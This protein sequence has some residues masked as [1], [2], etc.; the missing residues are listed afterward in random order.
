MNNIPSTGFVYELGSLEMAADDKSILESGLAEDAV[1]EG[2]GELSD[3]IRRM[4][5]ESDITSQSGDPY[6]LMLEGKG[7]QESEYSGLP[8]LLRYGVQEFYGLRHPSESP[9]LAQDQ[10]QSAVDSKQAADQK[11]IYNQRAIGNESEFKSLAK[12]LAEGAAIARAPNENEGQIAAAEL[13]HQDALSQIQQFENTPYSAFG[14]L[15]KT[16]QDQKNAIDQLTLNANIIRDRAVDRFHDPEVEQQR[17]D[18]DQLAALKMHASGNTTAAQRM[19]LENKFNAE[20]RSVDND[21]VTR[22]TRLQNIRDQALTN[23]DADAATQSKFQEAQ[24]NEH[25]LAMQEES[26]D[27]EL[28]GEGRDDDA[29]IS[30]LKFAT[31]QRV[32]NLREEADAEADPT[33]K[34]QLL[35]EAKA[36]SD[37]GKT[38]QDALQKELA[39]DSQMSNVQAGALAGVSQQAGNSASGRD[40]L[41][42]LSDVS[43]KLDDAAGKMEKAFAN[44]KTVVILK[45]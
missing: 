45:D 20:L 5:A 41:G 7:L 10:Y 31:E 6:Q 15:F 3:Q 32:R 35:R 16:P 8:G 37:A 28:R 11:Q 44:G 26:K 9:S 43:R 19:D 25:V 29:K 22:Q 38:E 21:D 39:R 17:D 42:N 40:S 34:A 13:Q 30:A 24:T 1:I 18:D 14:S 27:A 4:K 2:Y 36:A 33:H 23:F 12:N